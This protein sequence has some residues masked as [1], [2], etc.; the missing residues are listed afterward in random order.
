[1]AIT[2][3]TRNDIIE[4]VITAYNAAPG[5][6]LLSELVAIVDD[7][8]TLADV[9]TELTTRTEWTSTYPTF[10][11]AEEF[12]DEWLGNLVPEA[13]AD[14]LAE[15][16]SVAV[17]L[18][19]GGMSF[20]DLILEAQA[21]LSAASEDDAAFGSSAANFNNKVE[22]ATYHTITQ[23]NADQDSAVVADVTSDDATVQ[24]A[25]DAVDYVAPTAGTT[26]ALTKGLDSG[27]SFTGGAG[28]DTFTGALTGSATTETATTGDSLVGGAGTDR[29]TLS[30]SNGA[31]TP[32][33]LVATS[34]VEELSIFNNDV[35]G[36]TVQGD[37]MSGLTDIFVTAG[38]GATTVDEIDSAPNLH[39][40][41]TNF[42]ATVTPKSTT[43]LG[44][45]DAVTILS[46]GSAGTTSI[47]ATYNDA[48]G[49]GV[50]TVN[51]VGAGGATGSATTTLTIASADLTTVNVTGSTNM[52][53]VADLT[54]ADLAGEVSTFN[55]S[56]ATGN[57]DI[58]PTAG[59]STEMSITM[60]SGD[61]RVTAGAMDK[62][63]T[64]DGGDGTDTLEVSS[65]GYTA[66]LAAAGTLVGQ[67]VSNFET[68]LVS[69]SGSADLRS[70]TNNTFT[71]LKTAGDAT[72]NGVSGT[73]S[74]I[75]GATGTVTVNRAT[76]GA[77]D[78]ATLALSATTPGTY[79]TIDLAD[80]E[81]ITLTSGGLLAGSNT[82][83]TLTATDA[84]SLTINGSRDL[85]VTNAVGGTALATLDASGLTGQG[86]N[87]SIDASNSLAAM[88]VTLGAGSESSTSETMNTITT[89]S[90][91]DT[92]TGGD[93]KDSITTGSGADSVVA[94]GGNDV[95]VTSFGND[96]VDGGAGNDNI[97][98]SVGNDT[99]IGGAGN[100]TIDGAAGADSIDGGAGND[101]IYLTTLGAN[102]TVDGGTGTD[103][104]SANSLASTIV[105]ADFA[106]VSES[107]AL[108]FTEVE[109]AYIE[110][111][112]AAT[113]T[114]TA[115]LNMD[116]TGTSGLT[117]LNLD[118]N[119]TDAEAFKLTN[120]GG[121]S[122]VLTGL[123][124]TEDPEFIKIDGAEQAALTT[125][126]RGFAPNT[127]AQ[128]DL[129][130]T[131]VSAVTVKG[132]SYLSTTAQTNRVGSIVADSADSLTLTTDGS[133]SYAANTSAL[134]V[135]NTVS[136]TNA[137]TIT[138]NVGAKDTM[139][140]GTAN[141]AA[142][143][144]TA[145]NSI[146]QTLDIDVGANATLTIGGTDIN[147]G[148]AAVN[149]VTIDTGIG[150]T[151]D[152]L[153]VTAASAAS[154]TLTIGAS[155][156]ADIDLD[157]AI[158]SGS[159]TMSTG[160]ALTMDSLGKAGAASSISISGYGDVVEGTAI[161]LAGTTFTFNAGGLTDPD[162]LL[163]DASNLTGAGKLTGS[164]T[165]DTITGGTTTDTITGGLGA[166]DI[167]AS[168]GADSIVL[169]E[170][171][172][173]EDEVYY[174]G[175]TAALQ[176]ADAGDTITGFA[177]GA[178][179]DIIVFE[180]DAFKDPAGATPDTGAATQMVTNMA[181]NAD[182]SANTLAFIFQ[183]D[184]TTDATNVDT[185]AGAA[186]ALA[187]VDGQ[188][189]STANLIFAL[190]DGTDSYLWMWDANGGAS[191]DVTVDA[192]ELTL[193]ATVS[194]VTAFA[195]GDIVGET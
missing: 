74:I 75:A 52:W 133:G 195:A 32:S 54:G 105:A 189:G 124:A 24:T 104:L 149:A 193:I 81:T 157:Y 31:T 170:T 109:T 50:E 64:I 16:K 172:A 10:Q 175:T 137:Q 134:L 171:V 58:T 43:L 108:S 72:F 146:V 47:T 7:G 19:N 188:D 192:D 126:L 96:Y 59:G 161:V 118:V 138:I 18:I 183:L 11:T 154:T 60:G 158:T 73:P 84:T 130:F 148:S 119:S 65:A 117:T 5:T 152:P 140:I 144:I 25:K 30:I 95:V 27:A 85:T 131:G 14:A 3:E 177:E 166:D 46:N 174:L 93:Y 91:A 57:I 194:G 97:T 181:T 21:F 1:M 167:N 187:N 165:A 106:E 36:F 40:I 163:L 55:A 141:G 92:V 142:D 51:L 173:S 42:D 110:V 127:A 128:A 71:T 153:I 86:V 89:G 145:S 4:L 8:G 190:D 90:G 39:L 100:D 155:S 122:I 94:G 80:E 101:K 17:G 191:T 56:A 136:A 6:T 12:A 13:G 135:T 48:G 78:S 121:S 2:A 179:A 44:T 79:T 168:N 129:T 45:S 9:A 180:L 125:T 162:G 120:F 66:A 147:L 41:S 61:D 169:T 156:T 99:L 63:Y 35:G 114:T 113:D 33:N 159:I 83:T 37:L 112:T 164:D 87:L 49:A 62:D 151:I 67:G 186:A 38:Q 53:L 28:D 76:D 115:P 22:V 123:T 26:T 143:D 178:G 132:D 139:D 15:A 88:T 176:T 103:T 98:D 150:G 34:G 23:E 68:L 160:S 182:I 70:F 184:G 185:A 69:A 116:F 107:A 102:D 111:N 82:I 77:A 20:A 29:L